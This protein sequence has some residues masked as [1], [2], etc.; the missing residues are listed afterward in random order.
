MRSTGGRLIARP[1][2]FL[3]APKR[4]RPWWT[5]M[6]LEIV[7]TAAFVALVLGVTGARG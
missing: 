3:A 5:G 1:G 7:G 4:R 2:T 6:A